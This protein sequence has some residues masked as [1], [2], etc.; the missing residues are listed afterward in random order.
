MKKR[1]LG[2]ALAAAMGTMMLAGC[3]D[4]SASSTAASSSA[5]AE[6]AKTESTKEAS[7]KEESSKAESTETA[8]ADADLTGKKVCA[9]F[10]SLE[11][12][13]FSQFDNWMKEGL[14]AK[15]IEYTSQSSNMDDVMMIEQIE[16]AVANQN[17][18]IYVWA[19]NGAAV[20]D[21]CKAALDQ[22]AMVYCF[23]QDPGEDARTRARG[24]DEVE[25]G[26]A[27]ASFA[28]KWADENRP[29]AEPGS[30]RTLIFGNESSTNQ[31]ERTD[32]LEEALKA[33]G[34]FD[35]VE[36]L[37]VELSEVAGQSTAENMFAKYGD[38]IDCIACVSGNQV[39][40]T[41]AYLQSEAN[42]TED[43]EGMCIVG[44]EVTE[45]LADLMRK[46]LYDGAAVPG[47]NPYENISVQI[48]EIEKLLSGDTSL[49]GGF[50]AVDIGRCSIENL[51][52]FG[53]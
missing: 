39:I 33:D 34:R 18:L 43:P 30:I 11:G 4:S 45:A 10:F 13:F 22:G 42:I 53:Y 35:I 16:N 51:E 17:D 49:V 46:G 6:S 5:K 2:I 14:E 24:T 25:C 28:I 38:T 26:D 41:C 7:T 9:L 15:G 19:T 31:K 23:V 52:E 48:D 44:C 8:E 1:I 29:D 27:I 3:G 12:E 20:H 40:G 32:A 50:S 47:G 36:R 37:Q 21:A